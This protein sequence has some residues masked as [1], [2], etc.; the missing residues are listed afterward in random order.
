MSSSDIAFNRL[1]IPHLGPGWIEPGRPAGPALVEQVP[2]LVQGHL[3]PTEPLAIRIRR[4][5]PGLL[6]PDLVLLVGQTIDVVKHR[7]VLHD[8][9]LPSVAALS[10]SWCSHTLRRRARR[11][12]SSGYP[13][14]GGR[15]GWS[16]SPG[17]SWGG[18]RSAS[19]A[20]AG[21]RRRGATRCRP[22][23]TRSP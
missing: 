5:A 16:A 19:P 18:Y 12:R 14:S 1:L 2:T 23:R 17:R 10:I 22:G 15:S 11:V 7:V 3:D 4:F 20:P 8:L 21:G 6:A 13:S 9:P